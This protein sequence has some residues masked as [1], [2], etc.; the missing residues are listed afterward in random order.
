MRQEYEP[1][2]TT[3]IFRNSQKNNSKLLW[4]FFALGFLMFCNGRKALAATDA[5]HWIPKGDRLY[6]GITLRKAES[7]RR[8]YPCLFCIAPSEG[9]SSSL[10]RP[11]EER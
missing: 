3:Q 10:Q 1:E 6:D 2:L 7:T 9:D 4:T 8:G 5:K 11:P